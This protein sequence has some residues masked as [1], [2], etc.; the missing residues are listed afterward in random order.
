[1]S[2]GKFHKICCISTHGFI[3][4]DSKFM[5]EITIRTKNGA[6]IGIVENIPQ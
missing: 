1:M 2:R 5:T 6:K 4:Q 3:S